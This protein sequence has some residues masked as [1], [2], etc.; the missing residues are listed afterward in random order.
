MAGVVP[1][2]ESLSFEDNDEDG[3]DALGNTLK[4]WQGIVL[5]TIYEGD[6]H[7][8]FVLE[9]FQ[10]LV[11]R[12]EIQGVEHKTMGFGRRLAEVEVAVM[13]TRRKMAKLPVT[14]ESQCKDKMS[15]EEK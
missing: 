14:L 6:S 13:K 1:V 9:R 11:E 4:S 12:S 15:Q 8:P 3:G 2:A 7:R 10:A 5:Q